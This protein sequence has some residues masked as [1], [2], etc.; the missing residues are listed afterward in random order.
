MASNDGKG[1]KHMSW[2]DARSLQALVYPGMWAAGSTDKHVATVYETLSIWKAALSDSSVWTQRSACFQTATRFS[3]MHSANAHFIVSSH[4]GKLSNRICH[5]CSPWRNI[6]MVVQKF[7]LS[8]K[9]GRISERSKKA[10]T[11]QYSVPFKFQTASLCS[12]RR[13]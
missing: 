11:Q 4:R 9:T 3:F 1:S 13:L 12:P 6:I 2:S 7:L 8:R 5:H 10:K